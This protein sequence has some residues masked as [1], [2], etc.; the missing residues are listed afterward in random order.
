M[1]VN[2]SIT[3]PADRL[4]P[5]ADRY[6]TSLSAVARGIAFVVLSR[7][8]AE[9]GPH[10]GADP[11][12]GELLGQPG[13]PAATGTVSGADG[14]V[15]VEFPA[16]L[17]G[18]GAG[19]P[20]CC[21]I[22]LESL[23]R[24]PGQRLSQIELLSP[25]ERE[26][27][28]HEFNQT[29]TPFAA[30]A[31][32]YELVQAQAGR[33]P[34]ALAVIDG[35]E[36]LTY[37]ELNGRANRLARHLR[38]RGV[39]RGDLVGVCLE[40]SA[41]LVVA[42]LAVLKAGAAYVPLDPGYPA[43]RLEF[44]VRD[45]GLR[46]V[47]TSGSLLDRTPAQAHVLIEEDRPMVADTNLPPLA[48]PA[49]LAYVMYTSGSTGTP[50]GVMIEHR[51]ICR[52]IDGNW[53][54]EVTE[55]DVVA[56][57]ASFSFDPFTFEC[58]AA[59]T[60]G[61]RLVVLS[62]DTVLDAQKL[63]AAIR[64]HGISTIRLTASLFK[65]HVL[66]CPDLFTGVKTVLYGGEA[67]DRS[68]ADRLV[69]GP[70]APGSVVNGYGPTEA[71][72]YTSCHR[73]RP[74]DRPTMP[75][76]RP[77]SNT[78][79]FVMDRYGG[80][81]PV[82]IPG[83]LWVGGPGVARG[84]WNQPGLTAQRF[85]SHPFAAGARVYRTG[86]LARWLPT[87]ELEFLGRI[88][89]QV[90][91][92]GY[93]IEPQEIESVL[94]GHE[95]VTA[96]VVDVREDVPG[97]K[98]LIAYYVTTGPV[99]GLR[100]WCQ[101][102]LPDYMVPSTFVAVDSFPLTPNGKLDRGALPAPGRVGRY[103]APRNHVEETIVQTWVAVLGVPLVGVFDDF[104]DLGGHSLLAGQIASRLR[105]EL[106]VEV[107]IRMILDAPTVAALAGQVGAAQ[108]ALPPITSRRARVPSARTLH[109]CR[110]DTRT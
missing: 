38:D 53:F 63:K 22:A 77:I 102:R 28:R 9:D 68:V 10:D 76:G 34:D 11:T 35:D 85:V 62:R 92:R 106:G 43:R 110:R 108:P 72:T 51:S 14:G 74:G 88:D 26:R 80:L 2:E 3:L 60:S 42:V 98:R 25:R 90:K 61:A 18:A 64:Q 1:P 12:F 66:D 50:K 54:A 105:R 86:D 39:G 56:Q 109:R 87:G 45:T 95:G 19:L 49:D 48:G 4:R 89:Q 47:I 71:T 73:V 44:M 31:G 75:I 97:E 58:W 84:Y 101:Q 6:G 91:I 107:R 104:F 78:E 69:T 81:A 59:L 93:R 40:P 100:Q 29:A 27:V 15:R 7:Y 21:A 57:A 65:Q 20:Q 30:D 33:A 46:L 67:I 5:L 17:A 37:Q 94:A 13:G 55:M 32:V 24:D 23:A 36:A 79:V 41:D 70:W 99:E 52:L 103:V 16:D 96:A 8:A 82:G 83:E